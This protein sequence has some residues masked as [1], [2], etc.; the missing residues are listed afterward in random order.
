[1]KTEE[2]ISRTIFIITEYYKNNLQPFFECLSDD[3]LW[4]GPAQR[5]QIQGKDRLL[6]TFAAEKHALTF[7]M[8]DIKALCISPHSRVR[9]VVLHYDIYTHYPS[10]NT[11]MHD[12][13]LHFTW[14]EKLIRSAAGQ[15]YRQEIVM[16]H[17]SNAW[18]YDSQD[19]IY[20][21][22]Y[23]NVSAH[24]L[25]KPERYVM[26]R[27]ID[28]SLHRIAAERILY[29]ETVKRTA[30]L[31][32]HTENGTVAAHGKLSDF[33]RNYPDVFLRIHTSYLLNPAHVR[34]IRRFSVILSDGTELPVPEKKYTQ[35]KWLLLREDNETAA[36]QVRNADQSSGL[37]HSG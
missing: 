12:Q 19:T 3:V 15:E 37:P 2:M 16:V 17:V 10:G 24:S 30:K 9:E 21:I 13:R 14:R 35:I 11:D 5:Q 4:I 31:L 27:G 8:G 6:Q 33:E 32:V 29:I 20:P 1:M 22:H 25:T 28:I 36:P 34:K 18:R 26:V 23:E 7:T